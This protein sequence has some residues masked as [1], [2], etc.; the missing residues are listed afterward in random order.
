MHVP[1]KSLNDAIAVLQRAASHLRNGQVIYAH[2]QMGYLYDIFATGIDCDGSKRRT[3]N[4]IMMHLRAGQQIDAHNEIKSL[5]DICLRQF[6]IPPQ[7][8]P[9][10]VKE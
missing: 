5:T 7:T 2:R 3:V 1:N 10:T 4:L 8:N 9:P 6:S